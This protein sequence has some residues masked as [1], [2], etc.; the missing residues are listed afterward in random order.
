MQQRFL[1]LLQH[2]GM[3]SHRNEGITVCSVSDAAGGM[4]IAEQVLTEIIDRQ[5][6]LS[7]SGGSMKSLYVQ[8][9]QSERI[10]PGAVGLIDER[11]GKPMHEESNERMIRETGLFRYFMSK[12]IPL[13]LI[14]QQGKTRE[15]TAQLYDSQV[16]SLHATFQK[17]IGL[18][19]IGPDG[20][21][22]SIIPN[23]ADF[24]N[25]WFDAER[26]HLLVSEF[27]DP[28]SHYKERVGMTFLGLSMLDYIIVLA[29][30]EKK[31]AM[32]DRLFAQGSE[33][34]IPARFLKR[35]DIAKKTLLIT[36]LVFLPSGYGGK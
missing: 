7:L 15:E 28:K 9:A 3:S 14:L 18:L 1:D 11:F 20:H 34:E 13:Q 29:F 25:P 4:N 12:N 19:G 8:L 30:G 35:P 17:H 36:D 32:F 33:E 6:V 22:S 23:R 16:R 10:L 5:T 26:Q 2:N 24:H 21:I 27:D 31:Q